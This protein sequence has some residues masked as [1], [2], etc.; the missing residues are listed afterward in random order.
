MEKKV[1]QEERLRAFDYLHQRFPH[2]F[3]LPGDV[4][5]VEVGLAPKLWEELKVNPPPEEIRKRAI[6]AALFCYFHS[7][8]YRRC[9]YSEGMERVS[10]F[11]ETSGTVTHEHLTLRRAERAEK[12]KEYRQK[13]A[14]KRALEA[15]RLAKKKRL[16]EAAIKKAE[17]EARR[18]A[19]IKAQEEAAK[20]KQEKLKQ[21][22][23]RGSSQVSTKKPFKQKPYKPTTNPPN[24]K[25]IKQKQGIAQPKPK[26]EPPKVVLKKPMGTSRKPTLS[27]KKKEDK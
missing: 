3:R 4:K 7:H 13:R 5:P 11:G 23:L 14:E 17:K 10:L 22:S 25:V 18:Q 24:P 8:E 26:V 12:N 1:T 19:A 21:M 6:R 27:L 20:R 16:E 15:Q 2:A 9:Q